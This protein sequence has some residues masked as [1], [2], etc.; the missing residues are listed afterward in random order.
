MSGWRDCRWIKQDRSTVDIDQDSWQ[1]GGLIAIRSSDTDRQWRFGV[2]KVKCWNEYVSYATHGWWWLVRFVG[3]QMVRKT[4]DIIWLRKC[5]REWEYEWDIITERGWWKNMK[6]KW[7]KYWIKKTNSKSHAR[8]RNLCFWG[9]WRVS[10]SSY[11]PRGRRWGQ[12]TCWQTYNDLFVL[13]KVLIERS[14]KWKHTKI[15][16]IYST[17]L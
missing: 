13:A 12:D 3:D 5:W 10:S 4:M 11:G 15:Q 16:P 9:F 17:L 7:T 2:L 8:T 14:H 1:A 6:M